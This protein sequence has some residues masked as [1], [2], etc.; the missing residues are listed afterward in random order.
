MKTL[1]IMRLARCWLNN[2][3]H[4]MATRTTDIDKDAVTTWFA[5]FR[6]LVSQDLRTNSEQIGGEGVIVEVDETLLGRR[7]SN[8]GHKVEGA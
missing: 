3:T 6:E 4:G 2:E 5:A 8:R 1:Q 7:K